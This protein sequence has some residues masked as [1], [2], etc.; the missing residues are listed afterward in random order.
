M[1]PAGFFSVIPAAASSSRNKR[2]RIGHG[3][4]ILG[5]PNQILD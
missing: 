4:D 3:G 2:G 1:I 5:D